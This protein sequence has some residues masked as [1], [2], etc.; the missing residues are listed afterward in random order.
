MGRCKEN[1]AYFDNFKG[2]TIFGLKIL[3]TKRF[4]NGK[5]YFLVIDCF[6]RKKKEI[7]AYNLAFRWLHDC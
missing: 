4:R 7:N 3:D 6:T 2:K 5:R 1:D